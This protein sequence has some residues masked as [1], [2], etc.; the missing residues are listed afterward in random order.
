[1]EDSRMKIK[2]EGMKIKTEDGVEVGVNEPVYDYYSM[3]PCK[4][5]EF[6]NVER[7][8]EYISH[9]QQGSL[10]PWFTVQHTDTEG[11]PVG[12]RQ[13]LNGQRICSVEMAKRKGW[14]K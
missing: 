4:I 3:K 12:S 14:Y 5:V 6:D 2:T 11:N 10:T 8:D 13:Y 1:M 9:D 7:T